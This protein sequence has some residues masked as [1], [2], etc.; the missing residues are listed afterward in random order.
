MIRKSILAAVV[1]A[2]A[3]PAVAGGTKH[4]YHNY[5]TY[6]PT[7]NVIVVSCYRGPWNEVI[8]D[9]PNPVFVDSLVAVGYDFSTASAIAERVCKDQALVGD[10]AGLKANMERIWR[11]PSSHRR[12]NN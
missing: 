1:G 9:R 6:G 7:G 12:H 4:H 11:D 2:M 8:W 10:E 5:G 3:L